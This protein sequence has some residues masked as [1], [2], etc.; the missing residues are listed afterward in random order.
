MHRVIVGILVHDTTGEKMQKTRRAESPTTKDI[1]H[2]SELIKHG[3]DRLASHGSQGFT[4]CNEFNDF[5]LSYF[6]YQYAERE[7]HVMDCFKKYPDFSN[8]LPEMCT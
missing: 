4:Q 6:K 2:L 5:F 1:N 7:Y 3:L 8:Y